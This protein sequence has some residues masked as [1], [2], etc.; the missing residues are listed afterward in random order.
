MVSRICSA[1]QMLG[2]RCFD[3]VKR[4]GANLTALRARMVVWRTKLPPLDLSARRRAHRSS[5]F[6]ELIRA[7]D[8]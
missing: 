3:S 4:D 7:R 2:G 5:S 1:G 6:R 8:H